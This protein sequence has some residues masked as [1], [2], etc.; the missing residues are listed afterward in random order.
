LIIDESDR[1]YFAETLKTQLKG[2][3]MWQKKFLLGMMVTVVFGAMAMLFGCSNGHVSPQQPWVPVSG[4]LVGV[5][6]ANIKTTYDA[7]LAAVKKM[8]L[9][10][11]RQEQTG[12]SGIVVAKD[13][14]DKQIT[15]KLQ[16]ETLET[17]R[18]S[19]RV[20]FWADEARAR[21]LYSKIKENLTISK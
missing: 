21:V 12:L 17:T 16:A 10:V 5:E 18:I 6:S 14:N 7:A 8:D 2:M 13:L 3:I 4:N 19:I 15:I 11:T 20:G 1:Q 9:P